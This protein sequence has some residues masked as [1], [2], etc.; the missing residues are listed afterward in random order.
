MVSRPSRLAEC[1]ERC[2][3]PPRG[4]HIAICDRTPGELVELDRVNRDRDVG[5]Q[6]DGVLVCPIVGNRAVR[7]IFA[8]VRAGAEHDPVLAAVLD[9]LRRAA[10]GH[11][12]G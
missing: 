2:Q 4:R 12:A 8:A 5:E 3:S 10:A 6:G 7:N 9:E 1:L 11:T